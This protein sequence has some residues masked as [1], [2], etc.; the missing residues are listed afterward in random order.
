MTIKQFAQEHGVSCQAVYQK[1]KRNRISVD[2]L[3]NG[4]NP[5]GSRE[6][7]ENGINTLCQLFTN[8]EITLNETEQHRQQIDKHVESLEAENAELRNQLETATAKAEQLTGRVKE[9]EADIKRLTDA[10]TALEADNARI[11]QELTEARAEASDRAKELETENA[12]LTGKL[13]AYEAT[14]ATLAAMQEKTADALT[15]AQRLADQA[16]QLHAMQIKALPGGGVRNWFS[17]LF[18]K[19]DGE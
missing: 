1:L 18:K 11:K 16:Q 10:K 4:K 14:S 15:T 8:R 5:G 17:K 3:I 2:T 9:L 19:G 6:L 7:S 12:R 13:E